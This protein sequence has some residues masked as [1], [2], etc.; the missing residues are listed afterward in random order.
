MWEL[1]FCFLFIFVLFIFVLFK[2][3]SACKCWSAILESGSVC[4]KGKTNLSC[5]VMRCIL[6]V[7]T[8][9]TIPLLSENVPL[10]LHLG[11]RVCL[12]LNLDAFKK[13]EVTRKHGVK[14]APCERGCWQGWTLSRLACLPLS[15]ASCNPK[16]NQLLF[17]NCTLSSIIRVSD[18]WELLIWVRNQLPLPRPHL[19]DQTQQHTP[20]N[21]SFQEAP[22]AS[23]RDRQT[24][25]G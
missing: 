8:N 17:I 22:A 13:S 9:T 4:Q 1:G 16:T 20:N 25:A 19:L 24:D 10:I 18:S 14:A 7:S 21:S 15:E 2:N 11:L 3:K 23:H 5:E 6:Q 12:P